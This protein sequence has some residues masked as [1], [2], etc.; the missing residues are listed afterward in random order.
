MNHLH[1]QLQGSHGVLTFDREGSSANIFDRPALVELSE[2]LD[3]LSAHPELAGL[4]IRSAKPS[5]FIAGADLK[6]LS[7]AHGEELRDLIELGQATFDKLAHLPY[8]T[9]AA[10]HGACVGGG[11]ELALAC[12][13]RVASD[14][15]ATK[16]GLP[17]TQLGI[18]PAWGG[19][20]RLPRLIGLPAA[21]PLILAGKIM[22]AKAARAKGIVDAVVPQEHLEEH[23]LVLLQKG[24][25]HAKPHLLIHNPLVAPLIALKARADLKKKTHGLYPGPEA[26]LEVAAKSCYGPVHAGFEREREAIL[27]LA[28]RPETH[29]L[30]RL[31]FLQER[32]KKHKIVAAD[33]QP[34][35]RCA[36]I[37]AGVMGAGIAYWLSTRGHEVILRDLDDAA[38]AKGMKSIAKGYDEARKRRVLTP[39]EAARGIDRILPSSVPVP[40]DRCDLVIEAAVEKLDIKRKVF[41]DLSARTRP[42]TILATN[43]SALPVHELAEVIT[44]PERLVGLHFFNPVHRMQLVEVVRTPQTSDATLATAV[45]FVRS[46]GKLPVVVRDSPGFLVNR[47]LM[48]YLVEAA[49]LFE[50]GGDP[51]ELDDDMLDFGM[52]MGPLRL[53]DEVGLDVAAHVARTLAD[54]FPERMKV[55]DLLDKLIAKGHLGRKSGSGFY[56]YEGHRTRPNLEALALRSGTEPLPADT[57]RHLARCMSEEARLCLDEHV[58]ETADDIDLAMVLGTGY[59]P[60]RGGPLQYELNLA[61]MPKNNAPTAK[62]ATP[63]SHEGLTHATRHH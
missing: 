14:E 40:L 43:T 50:R 57:A 29:Q 30:L 39:T 44:H 9:V 33:P 27:Q 49:S 10:I 51:E 53:L 61:S 41:A 36:V 5:I 28:E 60:F 34:V 20:T 54:A 24:K 58:A 2:K 11:L 13:W 55:P 17:E 25:R 35:G 3:A 38:L 12:D 7:S 48:P 18:L 47:I 52:P 32:A 22:P 37:G 1:F 23:A 62:P 6:A 31:F 21:L 59:A 15:K 56:I 8:P 46:I 45:G 26:A 19:T 42:D 4:I 16:I 63:R